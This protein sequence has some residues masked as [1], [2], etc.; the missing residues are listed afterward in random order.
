MAQTGFNP[1]KLYRTTVAGRE[2]TAS[3]VDDGELAINTTDGKLFYKKTDGN[4][5][6]FNSGPLGAKSLDELTD[7]VVTN[8]SMMLGRNTTPT[9]VSNTSLGVSSMQSKTT[10]SNNTAI[11]FQADITNTTG[12]N[13]LV[14]GANST[15]STPSVSNEVTLGNGNI[16]NTRIRGAI[17]VG[18][19]TSNPEDIGPGV[20]GAVLESRGPLTSPVWSR[21]YFQ[22]NLE[23]QA[24]VGNENIV[25]MSSAYPNAINPP[26]PTQTAWIDKEG[27]KVVFYVSSSAYGTRKLARARVLNNEVVVDDFNPTILG[28]HVQAIV[29]GSR[30]SMCVQTL[31]KTLV[32]NTKSSSDVS[33]WEVVTDVTSITNTLPTGFTGS[34]TTSSFHYVVEFGKIIRICVIDNKK[35]VAQILSTAGAVLSTAEIFDSTATGIVDYTGGPI[36]SSG[37]QVIGYSVGLRFAYSYDKK[38]LIFKTST[39]YNGSDFSDGITRARDV[40]FKFNVP[41][42]VFLTNNASQII[43]ILSYF[44]FHQDIGNGINGIVGGGAGITYNLAWDPVLKTYFQNNVSYWPSDL[45]STAWGIA[46]LTTTVNSGGTFQAI[47]LP[48]VT[49][50]GKSVFGGSTLFLLGQNNIATLGSSQKYGTNYINL[51]LNG[52][53]TLDGNTVYNPKLAQITTIPDINDT[54]YDGTTNK[55][56]RCYGPDQVVREVIETTSGWVTSNTTDTQPAN[57]AGYTLVGR[58]LYAKTPNYYISFAYKNTDTR[59]YLYLLKYTSTTVVELDSMLHQAEVDG[60]FTATVG[61]KNGFVEGSLA[62]VNNT[63]ITV[64]SYNSISGTHAPHG[65]FYNLSTVTATTTNSVLAKLKSETFGNPHHGGVGFGA[66]HDGKLYRARSSGAPSLY[67]I[68]EQWTDV[69]SYINNA[70]PLSRADLTVTPTE[71]LSLYISP[72]PLFIGGYQRNVSNTTLQLAPNKTSYIIASASPLNNVD[73]IISVI[74]HQPP[75]LSESFNSSNQVCLSEITTDDQKILTKVD[76]LIRRDAQKLSIVDNV[77]SISR[78]NS[79][80]IAELTSSLPSASSTTSGLINTSNQTFTGTKT[81]TSPIVGSITGSAAS[82]TTGR[83]IGMTGDVTYTSS[84]FNG[85]ANVTGTATLANTGVSAGTYR[86]VTVDT[87]GR[88]TGGSNPTTLAGYGITDAVALTG[89]QTIAGT[90]TFSSTISGSIT[91]NSQTVG[92]LSVS[93]TTNNGANQIV[94]TDGNGY[95]NF[96]WINT[97]SGVASGTPARVYCSQDDYIRYYDMSTF[98]SYV[99]AAA[100]GE[101]AIIPTGNKRVSVINSNTTAVSAQTYVLVAALTLTLPASP[102]QGSW[103]TISNR[104]NTT[105]C[106]IGRNGQLIMGL[107]EDMTIDSL[108]PSLTLVFAD[109]T[110]GWV[111]S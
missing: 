32:M 10:G 19:N 59:N 38:E 80:S 105:S 73:V 28:E 37:F 61:Q 53:A 46:N 90:K 34:L 33:D 79:I 11:G 67:T 81:F 94:R 68:V 49:Y 95:A 42:S 96:G 101:W 108:N 92:G 24:G 9:G 27:Q 110:R 4:I 97:I 99:R 44:K 8:T 60:F 63:L 71:G 29:N 65:R 18:N 52:F 31:T 106:V 104:S 14:L 86:S 5:G 48:D 83:T 6:V 69:T 88:V 93:G 7:A 40:M 47:P 12:N 64:S 39:W 111:F 74:D 2:P 102:T 76:Y 107:A 72:Y 41:D 89:N 43:D 22:T 98:T 35:I 70:S 13:N 54:Y 84:A 1:I 20:S 57:P 100:T 16:T 23:P 3:Y 75:G 55:W 62:I 30:T 15:T 21:Y 58:P 45:G 87:K 78:G 56:R 91:G 109:A 103:V 51:P 17:S 25:P 77:L 50:L 82:L 26:G 66:T 36:P 85:T